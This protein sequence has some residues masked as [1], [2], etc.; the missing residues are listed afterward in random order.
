[1]SQIV[2]HG[3]TTVNNHQCGVHI[4]QLQNI[5][6][7]SISSINDIIG[8]LQTG[9]GLCPPCCISQA[10]ERCNGKQADLELGWGTPRRERGTGQSPIQM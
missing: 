7:E 10:T 9:E 5:S 3:I 2:T 4:S 8:I 6:I 1:M